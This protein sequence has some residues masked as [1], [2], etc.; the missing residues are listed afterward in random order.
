MY[1]LLV[2]CMP[3]NQATDLLILLLSLLLSL[4]TQGVLE[5]MDRKSELVVF[6]LPTPAR[7]VCKKLSLTPV[8]GVDPA[9]L[10]LVEDNGLMVPE[11]LIKLR[12]MLYDCNG[13][14]QEG[15]FRKAGTESELLPIR[16]RLNRHEEVVLTNP[17]NI[18]T[19]LKVW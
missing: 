16:E 19:L 9:T 15:I 6:S 7:I 3:L 1:A 5:P 2:C 11:I 17:H 4:A 12:Q 8:F 10:D 14:Q 13:L 18:A